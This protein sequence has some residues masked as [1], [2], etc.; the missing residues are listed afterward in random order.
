MSKD[1]LI[2]SHAPFVSYPAILAYQLRSSPAHI[3]FWCPWC[4][5]AHLHGAAADGNRASHCHTRGSPLA[6]RG[7]DLIY[8]GEVANSRNLPR[9]T[10]ELFIKASDRLVGVDARAVWVGGELRPPRRSWPKEAKP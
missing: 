5:K 4:K 7:Y 6:G 8:A 10:P 2:E 9:L 1:D 3:G